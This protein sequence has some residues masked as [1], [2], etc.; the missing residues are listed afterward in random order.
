MNNGRK[1][2]FIGWASA[3]GFKNN[4]DNVLVLNLSKIRIERLSLIF[5]SLLPAAGHELLF[6]Y[7]DQKTDQFEVAEFGLINLLYKY[8]VIIL[9]SV[10]GFDLSAAAQST[11]SDWV[12]A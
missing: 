6:K 8:D 3:N 12:K 2:L 5:I 11:L 4:G 9:P 7:T 1:N 10:F